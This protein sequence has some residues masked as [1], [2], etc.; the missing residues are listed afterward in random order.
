M[1][2]TPVFT[3]IRSFAIKSA[4]GEPAP[5]R[6]T[7]NCVARKTNASLQKL[8][9][10]VFR[11]PLPLVTALKGFSSVVCAEPT[12]KR[13]EAGRGWRSALRGG[14]N[15]LSARP[16]QLQGLSNRSGWGDFLPILR[17]QRLGGSDGGLARD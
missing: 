9:S 11:I 10:Q 12:D 8:A 16:A 4:A 13:N 6:R 7:K 1:S 15:F 17:I 14:P 5:I 2:P 3:A